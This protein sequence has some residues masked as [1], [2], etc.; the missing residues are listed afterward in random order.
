MSVVLILSIAIRLAA[1][2]VALTFWAR[3]RERWFGFLGGM[4]ALM[5]L[6]QMVTL[7][8]HDELELEHG[9]AASLD[10]LPG[11]A[12]SLLAFSAVFFP[13]AESG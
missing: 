4:I 10:E 1:L 5:A 9:L 2:G 7:F 6:R 11:L 3:L 8:A 12:V 13:E